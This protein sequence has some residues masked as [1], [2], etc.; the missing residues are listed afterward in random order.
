MNDYLIFRRAA[1]EEN[2]ILALNR[3]G[4]EKDEKKIREDVAKHVGLSMP[5]QYSENESDP[6]KK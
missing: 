2:H 4:Q 3:V 1:R 6:N 5:E